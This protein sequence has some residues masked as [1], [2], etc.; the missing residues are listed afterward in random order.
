MA[1]R[2]RVKEIII[3]G[4]RLDDL[5]R[6][7]SQVHKAFRSGDTFLPGIISGMIRTAERF[8]FY[9]T[10]CPRTGEVEKS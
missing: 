5:G 10:D 3:L 9:D 7:T 1:E 4:E 6:V 2:V 8:L